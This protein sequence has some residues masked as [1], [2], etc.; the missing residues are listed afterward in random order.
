MR[1]AEEPE[2]GRTPGLE[3]GAGGE[4]PEISIV[5]PCLNEEETLPDC[6]GRAREGLEA[7]GLRGEIVVV[8]NGST[9]RSAEIARSLGARVATEGVRG[10]G[11][12]LRRGFAEARAPWIVM[13]DADGSYDLGG[14][15]AFA[16]RLAEGCDLVMGSRLRGTI[17]PGAMPWLHRRVGTPALTRAL[18]L[19]HGAGI[20]DVNCGMRGFRRDAVPRMALRSD[21]M[22]LASEMVI[23]AARA[24][25][26][27]AEIPIDFRRDGRER[28]PH[29]RTFR[30]GWRH[31][32]LIV[33][34]KFRHR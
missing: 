11:A 20:S 28:P 32:S 13:A 10:Y 4:S 8:D 18:N 2:G 19:L 22:E 25:L 17:E 33:S 16:A 34:M 31:L 12:A 24:G 9:D 29:L 6:L 5:L 7:A 27:I 23:A 30:D 15:G 3:G 21:G 1:A 14:V 26:R